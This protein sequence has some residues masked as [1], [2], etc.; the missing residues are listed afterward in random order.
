MSSLNVLVIDDEPAVR[1]LL[2]AAVTK[3]GYSVNQAASAAEAAAK[4]AR[5]DV[6][7]ALCDIKM[8]D[9]NGIDLV[10]DSR[11]SGIDTTFI[12]VTA[13][14]SLD[15]AVDALRAGA[16]DYVCKPVCDEELLHRLAQLDALLVSSG[17]SGAWAQSSTGAY[18]LYI[19]NGGFVNDAFKA[20]F[21]TGFATQV[22]LQVVKK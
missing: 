15:T 18:L 1:Q 12:M 7:V 5:G 14:A 4:L 6:D 11:A 16:F 10:R 19:V 22:A 9:G 20:A 13:F 3:G 8:P 2:A 17:G 21:P